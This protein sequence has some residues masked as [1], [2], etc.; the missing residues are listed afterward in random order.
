ME[1]SFLI[2]CDFVYEKYQM[3]NFSYHISFLSTTRKTVK[4]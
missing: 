4:C 2:I 3:T 1:G